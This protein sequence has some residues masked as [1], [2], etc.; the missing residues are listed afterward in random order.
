MP[1]DSHDGV[2]VAQ[3]RDEAHFSIPDLVFDNKTR[4]EAIHFDAVDQ[5]GNAAH[6][7]VAKTAYTIG[8]ADTNGMAQLT[9]LAIPAPLLT[10]DQYFDDDRTKGVRQES[11]LAPYKPRCDVIVNAT[12]WAPNGT[13]L[14][15]FN[16]RLAVV[17]VKFPAAVKGDGAVSNKD[18]LIHKN[19]TVFG[20][21]TFRK[22]WL[23]WRFMHWF[24]R[25]ATVGLVRPLPWRLTSPKKCAQLPIRYEYAAGGE[26]RI[27]NGDPAAKSIPKKIRLPLPAD[28]KANPQAYSD[29][30]AAHEA[31]ETNPIGRGFVRRW[32][33]DAMRLERVPAPR[34]TYLDKPFGVRQFWRGARGEALPEPAGFCCV[35][36]GWLPRRALAGHFVDRS[37]WGE[38]DVPNLPAD[39]DFG[40]WNSAPVDQQCPH[41]SGQELI[42]LT[43]LCRPDYPAGRKDA[44]GHLTVRFKLPQQAIALLVM[45]GDGKIGVLRLVIDTVVVDPDASRVELVWRLCLPA[46]GVFRHAR[47]IH[48]TQADQLER[49]GQ[50]EQWQADAVTEQAAAA[51]AAQAQEGR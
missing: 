40:Y 49:L 42:A 45:D 36:R 17:G 38:D 20:E 39:F 5:H 14:R 7:F 6:V 8:Q 16:V 46:D 18:M 13:E 1:P 34:I 21:R 29:D 24:V 3:V 9:P 28:A 37:Q 31:S 47:L 30:A 22:K 44:D 51:P 23:G 2:Q 15:E 10:E 26:C 19:L 35:G 27:N 48:A 43:N 25:I 12:A 32:F 11:D 33:L 41:L 50:L 4:L